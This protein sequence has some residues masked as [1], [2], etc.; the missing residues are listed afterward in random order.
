MNWNDR[1]EREGNLGGVVARRP[2]FISP[3]VARRAM[4]RKGLTSTA[5]AARV[6]VSAATVRNWLAGRTAP[7]PG[8][9]ALLARALDLD[10]RDLTGVSP[11]SETL[12]DLRIHAAL[13]QSEVAHQLGVGQSTLSDVEIGVAAPTDRMR[14]A[15]ADL[16]GV[17]EADLVEAWTRSRDT[18]KRSR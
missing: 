18:L 3:A 11:G 5:V 8:K 13:T 17:A 9:L 6:D 1:V 10:T 14:G 2:G 4:D 15:L 12:S 7:V 16:Y